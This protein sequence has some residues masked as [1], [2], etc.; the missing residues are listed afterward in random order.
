[1]Q[2]EYWKTE[3]KERPNGY[4]YFHC[5]FNIQITVILVTTPLRTFSLWGRPN[6][7]SLYRLDRT[8]PLEF[9]PIFISPPRRNFQEKYPFNSI[10]IFWDF[11]PSLEYCC[12]NHIHSHSWNIL[13]KISNGSL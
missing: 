9:N 4:I 5:K 7:E 12:S 11:H 8:L 6:R 1:M 2:N 10:G 13:L 3:E